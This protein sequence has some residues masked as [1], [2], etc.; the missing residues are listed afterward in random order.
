MKKL[1]F[2]FFTMI[3]LSISSYAQGSVAT[4]YD[5]L[6]WDPPQEY[7]DWYSLRIFQLLSNPGGGYNR[8]MR[9]ID[10]LMYELVVYTDSTQLVIEND[11]LVF[12]D[13]LSGQNAFTTTAEYDTVLVSG[14]DSLDVVVVNAR[15]AVPSANDRL[16]VFLKPDTLIVGRASSGT[17]G[18][19]YNWVWIKK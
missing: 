10:S 15:E 1:L 8:N 5:T 7:T 9:D 11:T 19:K 13:N 2:I 3:V 12:A 18:L 17:S 6:G 16:G 14:L 4:P